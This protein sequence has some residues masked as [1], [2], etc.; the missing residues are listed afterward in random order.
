[1]RFP[2]DIVFDG[3]P[4]HEAPRFVEV[5]DAHGQSISIGDWFQR[6]DGYWVLQLRQS[7]LASML[8][9]PEGLLYYPLHNPW[10]DPPD[11]S[12]RSH[13]HSH[14]DGSCEGVDVGHAV[15]FWIEDL[16]DNEAFA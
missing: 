6:E 13:S 9:T 7:R 10:L 14:L 8:P 11:A 4:G 5:E 1:M 3:P 16:T 2:I 12:H 15:R